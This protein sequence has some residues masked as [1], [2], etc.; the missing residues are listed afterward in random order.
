MRVLSAALNRIRRLRR[1]SGQIYRE[2]GSFFAALRYIA[3]IVARKIPILIRQVQQL[4]H[5]GEIARSIASAKGTGGATIAIAISGGIGDYLVAA[6]FI[7]DFAAAAAPIQVDIYANHPAVAKWAFAPLDCVRSCYDDAAFVSLKAEYDVAMRIGHSIAI[8]GDFVQTHGAL[9]RIVGNIVEYAKTVDVFTQHQPL[10]DG[11]LAQTAVYANLTRA[12]FLH[13]MA[14]IAYGG[15]RY[16]AIFDSNIAA[17]H[18]L[19]RKSYITIHNGFDAGFVVAGKTATK[20]YPHFASVIRILKEKW[21]H[22]PFV[23][24]GTG[25][26]EP[27]AGSDLD[28]IGQTSLPEAAGLIEGALLHLD[29]EGGFVH[30]AR[31]LGTTS[32][33]VFGPTPSSYFGYPGNINIDPVFCG[34]CWSIDETWMSLCPRGFPNA[35]CMAEQ[36]PEAVAEAA[37]RFL[38]TCPNAAQP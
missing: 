30:L 1:M 15:D 7:R 16:N 6:R 28:L 32:C 31:C 33:V 26:S 5:R 13:W 27:I 3:R 17:K 12:N 18:N 35:R 22:L 29:N 4:A 9:R 10:M 11:F 38:L 21:P 34:G 2:T 19:H 8:A 37:H 25:T 36:P 23:Q 20:C 24:I 14:G